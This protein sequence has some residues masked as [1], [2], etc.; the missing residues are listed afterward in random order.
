MTNSQ[1]NLGDC[2]KSDFVTFSLDK[3]IKNGGNQKLSDAMK[4]KLKKNLKDNLRK[5]L[6]RRKKSDSKI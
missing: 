5:N 6:S 3:P 2:R 1:K 4:N